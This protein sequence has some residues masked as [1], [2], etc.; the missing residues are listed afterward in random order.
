MPFS[1][2]DI[3]YLSSDAGRCILE[4][5][6]HSEVSEANTLALLTQLR[7]ALSPRQ[8]AAVLSTLRLRKKARLKFPHHAQRML[9]TEESLQQASHPRIRQYRAGLLGS[10][11]LVDMCCGIGSDSFVYAESGRQVLGLDMDPVRI[12]IAR[13]NAAALGATVE[14]ALADVREGMPSGYDAAFYDPS[15]RD[16]MGKRMRDVERYA[17]PLSLIR[18]WPVKELVVKLSPAVAL[19]QVQ[20]YGG[21]VEFISVDGALSE[22]VLW[23]RRQSAPPLA[24]RLDASGIHH[25]SADLGER[26]EISEPR[27][28]LFEPDPAVLRARLLRQLATML[29]ARLL[30]DTIAYMTMDEIV[31]SPWGRY[32]QILDWMPFNLKRL[33]RYL[34]DRGVRHVTVKKRGFPM[35]PEEL[36]ARLRL[37]KGGESRVL[38]LTRCRARPVVIVCA[39]LV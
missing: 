21:Q 33:R 3:E 18:R 19:T 24:T 31:D 13:H 38:V 10:D 6:A 32:W 20:S 1:L 35:L 7:K 28:W 17:P 36:I 29:N 2:D 4:S 26:V 30:D 14:F 16:A 22:A 39:P 15:R 12:A 8:A 25:L 5:Y 37:K 9:F 34:I 27:A 11:K 23:R